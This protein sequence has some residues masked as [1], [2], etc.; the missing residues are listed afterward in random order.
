MRGFE[1]HPSVHYDL[2][3]GMSEFGFVSELL[4]MRQSELPNPNLKCG[5][6]CVRETQAANF[7]EGFTVGYAEMIGKRRFFGL[8]IVPTDKFL[9]LLSGRHRNF[10]LLFRTLESEL[11][12]FTLDH[13]R[14]VLQ[15]I[16]LFLKVQV[17]RSYAFDLGIQAFVLI[18]LSRELGERPEIYRQ[19]YN[20]DNLGRRS[21]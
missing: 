1:S 16:D 14:V 20:R 17:F 18:D 8:V 12:G 6:A 15:V 13:I 5:A 7:M 11:S 3:F 4:N 21:L 2:G 9:R 19:S 10:F